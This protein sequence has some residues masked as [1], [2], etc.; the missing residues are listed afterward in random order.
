ML[1]KVGLNLLIS[2]F[3]PGAVQL[4]GEN[5]RRL[6]YTDFYC[7]LQAQIP[8]VEVA[9]SFPGAGQSLSDPETRQ[10]GM[11]AKQEE[12]GK[13]SLLGKQEHLKLKFLDSLKHFPGA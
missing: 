12:E 3:S 13:T 6:S 1:P 7:L 10:L 9:V 5:W 2:P 4:D 11:E 8:F